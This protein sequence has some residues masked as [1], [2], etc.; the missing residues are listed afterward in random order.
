MCAGLAAYLLFTKPV[1]QKDGSYYGN[2]ND[3]EYLINDD[4]APF[5]HQAWQKV[6]PHNSED[7]EQL[8]H[9]VLTYQPF[10]DQDMRPFIG[11][12]SK[13]LTEF[14]QTSVREVLGSVVE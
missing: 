8:V 14:N 4:Q 9:Q 10:W 12:T 13:Y 6:D 3:K 2:F 11:L 7:I 5:F 1:D